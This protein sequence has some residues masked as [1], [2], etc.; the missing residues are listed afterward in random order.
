MRTLFPALFL[1]LAIPIHASNVMLISNANSER[2]I[3]LTSGDFNQDGIADLAVQYTGNKVKIHAGNADSI[4]RDSHFA[5]FL[6]PR[7]TVSLDL[8]ENRDTEIYLRLNS[9]AIPDRV[10]IS[11]DG[12]LYAEVS[13]P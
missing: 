8:A 2:A 5:P 13:V 4:Y 11:E 12:S 10:F 9:D 7:V 3:A 6:K 1:S